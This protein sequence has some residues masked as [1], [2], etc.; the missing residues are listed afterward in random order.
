MPAGFYFL[1]CSKALE[2]STLLKNN[3]RGI[4]M[5]EKCWGTEDLPCKANQC[6][7]SNGASSRKHL[8]FDELF[9]HTSAGRY[10]S[11]LTPV[12]RPRSD[13]IA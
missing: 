9:R 5:S 1:E 4:T 3:E 11:T 10:T 6:E 2:H 13:L 7:Q 12:R 8:H